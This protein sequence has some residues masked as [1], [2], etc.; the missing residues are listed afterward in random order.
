MSHDTS[1]R[2][3]SVPADAIS[4]HPPTL[5]VMAAD[6]P[7]GPIVGYEAYAFGW[8]GDPSLIVGPFEPIVERRGYHPRIKVFRSGYLTEYWYG[9]D[10]SCRMGG[11]ERPCWYQSGTT[12]RFIAKAKGG[13]S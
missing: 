9:A 2:L 13:Q 4:E 5:P 12:L 7:E 11:Y 1:L 3:F 10:G 8:G 6:I